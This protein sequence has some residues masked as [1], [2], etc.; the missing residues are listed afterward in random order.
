MIESK[1][2]VDGI[3][4]IC[5]YCRKS[6]LPVPYELKATYSSSTRPIDENIPYLRQVMA[7]CYVLGVTQAYLSRLE[8]MGNWRSVFGRKGE[9]DLPENRKP[10][11]SAYKITFTQDELDANWA[12]L[13]QRKELYEG[14]LAS[15]EGLPRA[16]AIA[17]G[18]TWLCDRCHY[19]D[20]ECK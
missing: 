9:K 17:D 10:T 11:L 12:W 20:K 3:A 1:H 15:G 13:K 5:P 2:N 14:V 18:Q 7:Q 6:T 4:V 19:R 8:I 16:I